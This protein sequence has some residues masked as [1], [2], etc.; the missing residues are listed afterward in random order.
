MLKPHHTCLIL[1]STMS[2][3]CTACRDESLNTGNA[4]VRMGL[5]HCSIKENK[6]I[7]TIP[8]TVEGEQN[9]PIHVDIAVMGSQSTAIEDRHYYITGKS[10]T[11]PPHKQSVNI[12]ISAV[13]D[14][15]VNPDRTF[16]LQ[17]ASADGARISPTQSTC[18]VT[19]LDNDNI[20]YERL[21]GT[22]TVHA[23]DQGP[24]GPLAAT[25][26]T[27]LRPYDE[28]DPRYGRQLAMQGW[29][30]FGE[31]YDFISMPLN[32]S[33]NDETAEISLGIALGETVA[34]SLNF[35]GSSD[36]A[37]PNTLCHVV[38][39]GQGMGYV[40]RGSIVGHINSQ[41][42][43]IVFESGMPLTGIVYNQNGTAISTWMEQDNIVLTLQQ[44]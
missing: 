8:V 22:W 5:T 33:Y 12:E 41:G 35:A 20:P 11:I 31:Y 18:N 34:D 44:P 1:A 40:T 28:A 29:M 19:L 27:Q 14:R 23:I 24:D 43:T 3:L 15:I 4:T 16:T 17:I 39:A 9:G 38:T 37:D 6:G 7:F 13:D 30:A 42:D 26:Q 10:L 2:L 36:E 32:F 21:Q 25:W